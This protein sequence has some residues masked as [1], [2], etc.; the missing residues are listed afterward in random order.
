VPRIAISSKD[1]VVTTPHL[2]DSQGW[3]AATAVTGELQVD[4][5]C[6]CPRVRD[7]IAAFN[8][9][10]NRYTREAWAEG[11]EFT[12]RD[13]RLLAEVHWPG[14]NVRVKSDS[15]GIDWIESHRISAPTSRSK[16]RRSRRPPRYSRPHPRPRGRRSEAR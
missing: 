6:Q 9:D 5:G 7:E 13:L 8:E 4:R 2:E 16:P 3:Y 1:G 11:D 10:L 14:E 15:L 12:A